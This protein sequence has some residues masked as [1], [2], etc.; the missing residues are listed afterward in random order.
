MIVNF[1]IV[2]AVVATATVAATVLTEIVRSVGNGR[3]RDAK[4]NG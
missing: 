2:T 4:E 1:F 3:R